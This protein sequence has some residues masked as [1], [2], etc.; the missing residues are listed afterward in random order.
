[1]NESSDVVFPQSAAIPFRVENGKPTV[2][3][4]TTRRNK[5][6]I[7]PKGLI[8]EWQS[9][10]DAALEEA[11]EEAGVRG[12]LVGDPVGFFEY[13][14]WGG[15]CHV[16]VFLMRV[17]EIFSDWPEADIRDRMWVSAEEAVKIVENADLRRLIQQAVARMA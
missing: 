15:I 4:I 5:K 2:L 16:E 1:M 13:E 3:L 17:A 10:R 14:K 8:E 7:V 11:Y 12:E 6:W 9:P